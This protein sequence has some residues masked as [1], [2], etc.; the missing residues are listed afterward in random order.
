MK[1]NPRG[2]RGDYIAKLAELETKMESFHHSIVDK[3]QKREQKR[4]RASVASEGA[5]RR[6]HLDFETSTPRRASSSSGGPVT[7]DENKALL[8]P[9]FESLLQPLRADVTELMTQ[10]AREGAMKLRRK[11]SRRLDSPTRLS[12]RCAAASANESGKEEHQHRQ[13]Q[14]YYST[15]SSSEIL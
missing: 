2:N 6:L 8:D 10:E 7:D 15:P 1:T 3:L 4:R 5:Q 13:R 12:P 14:R 11:R 9:N